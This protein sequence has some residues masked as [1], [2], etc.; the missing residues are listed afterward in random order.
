MVGR[1]SS[2][3]QLARLMLDA[4]CGEVVAHALGVLEEL[5]GHLGTN[6]VTPAVPCICPALAI[7]VP[8]GHRGG[9]AHLERLT[10]HIE[11]V[12]V[13]LL[14]PIPLSTR[15]GKIEEDAGKNN[16]HLSTFSP[17]LGFYHGDDYCLLLTLMTFLTTEVFST[18]WE[19]TLTQS[20]GRL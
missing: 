15:D 17:I 14:P 12:D 7:P 1:L 11:L 4:W 2:S 9:R 16:F 5:L 19:F 6:G 18:T 10:I 20:L 3:A 8:A 13:P